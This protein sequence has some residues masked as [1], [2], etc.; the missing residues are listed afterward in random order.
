MLFIHPW[1]ELLYTRFTQFLLLG[2][3]SFLLHTA[4]INV[5]WP[6]FARLIDVEH[7]PQSWCKY[8]FTSLTVCKI[9]KNTWGFLFVQQRRLS[10]TVGQFGSTFKWA[11]WILQWM[12]GFHVVWNLIW[13]QG[14]EVEFSC[15]GKKTTRKKKII[16]G[17]F[18]THMLIWIQQVQ[19]ILGQ[20]R[21]PGV[22]H[23]SPMWNSTHKH[24][25]TPASIEH[26]PYYRQSV[27]ELWVIVRNFN[28][29]T[30]LLDT[31]TRWP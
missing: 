27:T 26:A 24:T 10:C 19:K 21:Q 13:Y 30:L 31:H 20:F 9:C 4:L 18:S 22:C 3:D 25:Q 5:H 15:T 11:Q 28:C 14:H 17:T 29:F 2:W 1:W 16:F 12:K 8:F 6:R 7:I 23:S